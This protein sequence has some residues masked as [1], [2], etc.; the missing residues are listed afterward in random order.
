MSIVVLH[1]SIASNKIPRWSLKRSEENPTV[2]IRCN[3]TWNLVRVGYSVYTRHK[4]KFDMKTLCACE[5]Y[6]NRGQNP[7][8]LCFDHVAVHIL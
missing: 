8:P 4:C 5:L 3:L 2:G 7:H 6:F 1:L